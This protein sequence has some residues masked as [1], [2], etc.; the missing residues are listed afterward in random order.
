MFFMHYCIISEFIK[1]KSLE[2][3]IKHKASIFERGRQGEGVESGFLNGKK[4]SIPPT[5]SD[6]PPLP[7]LPLLRLLMLFYFIP[8]CCIDL[9]VDKLQ[10]TDELYPRNRDQ[11]TTALP[12]I[13]EAGHQRNLRV[14]RYLT[15]CT[16]DQ[17]QTSICK[18]M[19]NIAD[20]PNN[21]C[22][23]CVD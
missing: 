9:I 3:K 22:I 1:I 6:P 20:S 16:A 12:W 15:K 21:T 7:L 10:R 19:S 11:L 18:R 13:P 5:L 14:L 8:S 17:R 23:S 2:L 4:R